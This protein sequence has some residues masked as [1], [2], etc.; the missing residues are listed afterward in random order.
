MYDRSTLADEAC[1]RACGTVMAA[2]QLSCAVCFASLAQ[3]SGG[4]GRCGAKV[5]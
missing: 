5:T 2:V 1:A 3:P 4:R